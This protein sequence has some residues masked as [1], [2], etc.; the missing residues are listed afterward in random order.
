MGFAVGC[1][2]LASDGGTDLGQQNLAIDSPEV[3]YLVGKWI[4]NQG[5]FGH[6]IFDFQA[7]GRLLIEDVDTEQTFKMSYAF[8]GENSIVISGY[9]EFDGAATLNFYE[10]KLDF[11]INFEGSIYGELYSFTRVDES[12]TP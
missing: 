10:N 7:D 12:S 11:T 8:V 6:K 5:R 4:V 1:G 9:E 2:S 3:Q